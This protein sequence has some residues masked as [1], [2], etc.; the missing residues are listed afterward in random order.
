EIVERAIGGFL[1]DLLRLKPRIL[2]LPQDERRILLGG[3]IHAR[4]IDRAAH[5][6]RAR[7]HDVAATARDER[8]GGCALFLDA[9]EHRLHV[10]GETR[11][12]LGGHLH[13]G[14]EI[15]ALRRIEDRLL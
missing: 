14:R 6:R 12:T 13:A 4:L 1:Y 5:A 10:I 2:R 15:S 11:R 7:L 8:R 3:L 9:E